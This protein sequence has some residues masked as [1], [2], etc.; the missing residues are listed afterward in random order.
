ML[1]TLKEIE[2]KEGDTLHCYSQKILSK[3]IRFITKGRVSHTAKVIKVWNRLFILDSQSDGSNLRRLDNWEEKYNYTY[4]VTR[5]KNRD[6]TK[7]RK[8]ASEVIGV[9]KYDYM[10]LI[11]YQPIYQ[12]TGIWFGKKEE[13][14]V[15]KLYCSELCAWLD[16]IPN[17]WELSPEQLLEYHINSDEYEII[18]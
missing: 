9:T 17:Y 15:E 14:A 7:L 16:D 6:I 13:D 1:K 18:K 11:I 10:S 4:I 12:I 5:K 3:I 8:K 2:L